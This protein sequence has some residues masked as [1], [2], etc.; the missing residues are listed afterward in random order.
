MNRNEKR[1]PS[2]KPT[3]PDPNADLNELLDKAISDWKPTEPGDR[4]AGTV[5]ELREVEGIHSVFPILTLDTGAELV[6]VAC[7]RSV[8]EREVRSRDIR[9]GDRLAVQYEGQRTSAAGTGYHGY[10]VV[11]RP[12]VRV[13]APRIASV[14]DD[15][16]PPVDY[17]D[18]EVY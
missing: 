17:D 13:D 1:M 14:H 5:V 18:S 3:T 10:R 9:E 15:D 6:R 12:T 16:V 4:V 7:S 2:T 8:L 11:H